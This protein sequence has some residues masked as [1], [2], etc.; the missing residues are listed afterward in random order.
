MAELQEL[1]AFAGTHDLAAAIVGHVAA[2]H[3]AQRLP[4]SRPAEAS[5]AARHHFVGQRISDRLIAAM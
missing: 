4:I 5:P 3:H 2:D 1:R